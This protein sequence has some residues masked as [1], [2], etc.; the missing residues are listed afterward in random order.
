[1]NCGHHEIFLRSESI[2]VLGGDDKS[3]PAKTEGGISLQLSITLAIGFVLLFVNII[4]FSFI[5][6]RKEK[7]KFKI[8]VILIIH[9]SLVI[10]DKLSSYPKFIYLWRQYLV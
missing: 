8:K 7:E 10:A 3:R 6:Y 2:K 4:A 9:Y 5:S 1:M